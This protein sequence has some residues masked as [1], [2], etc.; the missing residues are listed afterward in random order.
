MAYFQQL[1]RASDQRRSRQWL[2]GMEYLL[3]IVNDQRQRDLG[4]IMARID[5]VGAGA[6]DGL[7]MTNF[8]LEELAGTVAPVGYQGQGRNGQMTPEQMRRM[9]QNDEE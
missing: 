5:A 7:Q 9:Q 4:E 6:R 2:E 1:I 3:T 8:R